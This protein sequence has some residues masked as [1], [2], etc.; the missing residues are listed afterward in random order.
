MYNNSIETLLSRHYGSTAPTPSDLEQ[1]IVAS[2]RREVENAQRHQLATR[3]IREQRLSRR[4]IVQMVAIGSTGLGILSA[5]LEGL[6][7][8][9]TSLLAQDVTQPAIP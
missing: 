3:S 6:Q 7:A 5:G 4:R 1:R 9:E 8:L 2:V